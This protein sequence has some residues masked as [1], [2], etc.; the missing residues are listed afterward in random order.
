MPRRK[1]TALLICT[2]SFTIAFTQAN[3]AN[4]HASKP[5]YPVPYVVPSINDITNTLDKVYNYLNA[6]TPAVLVN[7]N[8]KETVSLA[9]ADTNTV[10]RKVISE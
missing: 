5:D 6:N 8:T 10:F 1:L 4:L 2:C 9:Q 3:D 7:K